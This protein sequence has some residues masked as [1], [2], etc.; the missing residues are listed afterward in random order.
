M[1]PKARGSDLGELSSGNA[2]LSLADEIPVMDGVLLGAAGMGIR[3]NTSAWWRAVQLLTPKRW[4]QEQLL[5]LRLRQKRLKARWS[6]E[7]HEKFLCLEW[8]GMKRR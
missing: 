3:L 6:K 4:H 2:A 8:T 7:T 1:H 5:A